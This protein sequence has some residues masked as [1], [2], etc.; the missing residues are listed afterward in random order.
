M[1]KNNKVAKKEKAKDTRPVPEIRDK[2][3]NLL[4]L[5]P[6]DFPKSREGKVA[7]CDYQIARWGEK[8]VKAE[9]AADPKARKKAKVEKLKA[10]LEKLE[11]ELSAE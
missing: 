7:Y 11:K 1:A 5:K 3:G 8:K 4:K 10:M 6:K 9:R 2:E